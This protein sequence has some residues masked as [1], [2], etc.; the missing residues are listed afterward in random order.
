MRF[1]M[2]ALAIMMF[3]SY[4]QAAE[5]EYSPE[6][7][8]FTITFP[9]EPYTSR[10]CDEEGTGKCYDL[11]SYTKV[12]DMNATVNFRVICNPIADSIYDQYDES[13]MKATLKAMTKRSVVDT[14]SSSY[15]E[16]DNYKQAGLVGEGLAGKTSTIYIAQLWIGHESAL[17]V[18]AELI[19]EQNDSADVLFK[20]ILQTVSFVGSDKDSGDEEEE[21][22]VVPEDGDAQQAAPEEA[23]DQ[24]TEDD[25]SE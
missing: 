14:F 1:L 4:A 8:E 12:Y 6:M 23:E 15:R 10:R 19:G 16:E 25:A 22:G 21:D 9:E 20:D 24:A 11:V 13:V 5:T 7:C 2:T 17:S 18:E 3:A